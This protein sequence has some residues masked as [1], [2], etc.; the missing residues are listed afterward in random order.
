MPVWRSGLL[1][2]PWRAS[3]GVS[4]SLPEYVDHGQYAEVNNRPIT[5]PCYIMRQST[6]QE[7]SL[8]AEGADNYTSVYFHPPKT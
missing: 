2:Y 6:L 4:L 8:V 1:G 7:I 5:G 3:I